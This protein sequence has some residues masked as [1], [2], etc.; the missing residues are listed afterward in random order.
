MRFVCDNPYTN[1]G[2]FKNGLS[3]DLLTSN[4]IKMIKDTSIDGYI[5]KYDLSTFL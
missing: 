4:K 5:I 2:L 1:M 3:M